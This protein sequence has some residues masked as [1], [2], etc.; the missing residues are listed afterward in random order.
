MSYNIQGKTYQVIDAIERIPSKDSFTHLDNKIGSGAGA[1]EWHIGSK[2]DNRWYE[3]FEGEWFDV[4]CCLFKSDLIWL[5]NEL[6]S[7]Y[8]TPTQDYRGRDRFNGIWQNRFERINHLNNI[9]YFKFRRHTTRKETDNRLYAQRP[10]NED[11]GDSNYGLLRELALPN[12]TFISI[13]KLLADDGE[14]LFYFKIFP[15]YS[16]STIELPSDRRIIREI[17]ESD[18][19][20]ETEKLQLIKSRIGQGLFRT[21]LLD[22]VKICPITLINDSRILIASHIK[23]WRASSNAERL[24]V[25]NGLLFTPTYDKLFDAGYITFTMEKRIVVSPW[26][27]NDTIEKLNIAAGREYPMLYIRGREH[28]LEYHRTEIFKS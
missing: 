19:I 9:V 3:F 8:T 2:N 11:D 10:G 17:N 27:S 22:E 23:P 25:K 16:D 18:N 26:L 15:E 12:K 4:N 28:Y 6:H 21:Q 1:W 14:I 13:L 5:M 7:E 20:P 24:D